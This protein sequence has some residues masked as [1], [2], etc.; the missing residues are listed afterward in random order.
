MLRLAQWSA[1]LWLGGS[2][3][4]GGHHRWMTLGMGVVASL[5][6]TLGMVTGV[7]VVIVGHV[8]DVGDVGGCVVAID[9][10]GGGREGRLSSS[11]LVAMSMT[12]GMWVVAS[13]PSMLGVV[14]RRGGHHCWW[15]HQ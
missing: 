14:A 8:K 15:P 5:P 3:H 6:S 7:V 2:G 9:T 12:W 4:W 13:L 10:G 1:S 11:L